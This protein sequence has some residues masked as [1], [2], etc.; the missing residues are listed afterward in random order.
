MKKHNLPIRR[1]WVINGGFAKDTGYDAFMHLHS[2]GRMPEF[3][4]AMTY[5]IALGIYEA[6]HEL[7]LRIPDDVDI[8]CFGD[9]DV[10]RV[11]SPSLSCVAQPAYELGTK[12]VEMMLKATISPDATREQHLVLPTDL[13]LRETCTGRKAVVHQ[14]GMVHKVVPIHKGA[15]GS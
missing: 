6:A 5:P 3:I 10:A 9:S 8:I 13:L 15:S 14:K 11:I 7:G 2:S 12:A 1:E 4:F